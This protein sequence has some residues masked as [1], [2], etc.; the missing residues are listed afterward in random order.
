[1]K[2]SIILTTVAVLGAVLGLVTYNTSFESVPTEPNLTQ[3]FSP[4]PIANEECT[5]ERAAVCAV[6]VAS[7]IEACVTAMEAGGV[8]IIADI[9]CARARKLITDKK[10]CLP[11]LCQ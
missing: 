4:A 6:F 1:M 8:D 2:T 9:R 5:D 10:D 7:I 3:S 11:C